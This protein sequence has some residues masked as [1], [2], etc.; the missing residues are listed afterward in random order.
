MPNEAIFDELN[1]R[2]DE[3]L[4]I[5]LQTSVGITALRIEEYIA[6][7]LAE[8][9]SKT[10]VRE[11]LF[12]DFNEGGRIFGEFRKSIRATARGNLR[13]VADIGKYSELGV[14][15]AYRWIT[16]RDRNVC[17]DCEPRHGKEEVW[18][19]WEPRGMPRSVWSVCKYNCRCDIVPVETPK[20]ETVVTRPRG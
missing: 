19:E 17:P 1:N 7:R 12:T 6:V 18:E 15:R 11:E 13:T 10:I 9:A 20:I 3:V 5:R 16:V 4:T 2:E 8:G 14:D